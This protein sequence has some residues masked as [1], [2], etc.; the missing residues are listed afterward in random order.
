[1]APTDAVLD[2]LVSTG[3]I[4]REGTSI[5]LPDHRPTTEGRAEADH[6]VDAVADAEPIPPP[7]RGLLARASPR[8]LIDAGCGEGRLRRIGSDLVVTPA[9]L[10]RAEAMVR[11][12]AGS[13]GIT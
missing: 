1:V 3:V 13:D 7:V 6:L 5:R 4:A 2:H 9:F 8:D 10:S 12:S 11:A